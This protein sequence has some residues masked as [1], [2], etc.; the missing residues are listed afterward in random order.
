MSQETNAAS[1]F[2]GLLASEWRSADLCSGLADATTG[3]RREVLSELA[4]VKRKHAARW[5]AKLT[6]PVPPADRPGRRIAV[7]SWLARRFSLPG[8]GI[9]HLIGAS[10]LGTP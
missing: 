1:R 6:E 8:F 5:A 4:A 10:A 2:R 9:G 3:E 7:R